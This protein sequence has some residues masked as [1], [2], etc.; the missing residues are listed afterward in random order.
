[1]A[2]EF[3]LPDNFSALERA[4]V[5]RLLE[6]ASSLTGSYV[7]TWQADWLLSDLEDPVWKLRRDRSLDD[8]GVDISSY[9]LDWA[10]YLSDQTL[11]T[12]KKNKTLLLTMQRLAFLARE[13]PHTGISSHLAHLTWCQDLITITQWLHHGTGDSKQTIALLLSTDF[14]IAKTFITSFSVRG[15]AHSLGAIQIC[16]IFFRTHSNPNP[17]PFPIFGDDIYK[18]PEDEISLICNWLEKGKYYSINVNR[19]RYVDRSKLS[20]L[21]K[22][23]L[24]LV[25]ST[26]FSAFLRQFEPDLEKSAPGL[27]VAGNRKTEYFSHKTLTREEAYQRRMPFGRCRGFKD[28]FAS[29]PKLA[30]A[31]GQIRTDISEIDLKKL[32]AHIERSSRPDSSTAW[33]PL[34]IMLAYLNE[35]LRWVIVFGDELVAFYARAL[36]YL[37]SANLFHTNATEKRDHW[38]ASNL[39]ASLAKLGIKRWSARHSRNSPREFYDNFRNNPSMIDAMNILYGAIAVLIGSLKPIRMGELCFLSRDCVRQHGHNQYWI[40]HIN[41]KHGAE[42]VAE[43]ID[44]PVPRV[45]SRAISLLHRL[46]SDLTIQQHRC[47]LDASST[48]LL[49]VLPPRKFKPNFSLSGLGRKEIERRIDL[50]CDYVNLPPDKVGRRWYVRIHE[51]RKSFLLTFFWSTKFGSLDAAAWISGHSDVDAIYAY[52]RASFSGKEI[53]EL[54]AQYAAEQLWDFEETSN[55]NT[56]NISDLYHTVCEHFGVGEISKVAKSE[57]LQWLKIAFSSDLYKIDIYHLS[58]ETSEWAIAFKIKRE[59]S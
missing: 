37:Y 25:A 41:E 55:N 58:N 46:A 6:I 13:T 39:P 56:V 4:R 33:I 3:P 16:F 1:M 15:K 32:S 43:T 45:V 7:G 50:F 17:L 49:F 40:T 48:D 34:E 2:H 19:Q 30:R 51:L 14:H 44:R 42:G 8:T 52:I 5:R 53:V 23:D 26:P 31:L 27:M 59:E 28:V 9:E 22:I 57:L 29:L 24:S 21:L 10:R 36:E 38:I 20:D 18:L 47:S 12:D 35:A 11:L 54:E